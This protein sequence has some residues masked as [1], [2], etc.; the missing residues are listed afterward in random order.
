SFDLLKRPPQ[1][2]GDGHG[3][4]VVFGARLV[5]RLEQRRMVHRQVGS[6]DDAEIAQTLR[7][8]ADARPRGADAL[9][10]LCERSR[11]L[12]G[13]GGQM[14]PDPRAGLGEDGQLLPTV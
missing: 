6:G 11:W 7:T 2:G 5:R 8:H 10:P 14:E 3:C 13:P 1:S 4:P 9:T 12:A